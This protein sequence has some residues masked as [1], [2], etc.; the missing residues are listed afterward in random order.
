MGL[1]EE[2]SAP[3]APGVGQRRSCRDDCGGGEEETAFE[4]GGEEGAAAKKNSSAKN[5]KVRGSE[6]SVAAASPED[7]A[8]SGMG[9]SNPPSLL[10]WSWPVASVTAPAVRNR[11]LLAMAWAIT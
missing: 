11:A 9:L 5:P 8:S 1:S 3:E 7:T 2:E 10:R 4:G 6:V